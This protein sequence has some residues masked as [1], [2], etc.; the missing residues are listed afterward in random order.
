MT[1]ALSFRD[2]FVRRHAEALE[3]ARCGHRQPMQPPK[4]RVLLIHEQEAR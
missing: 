4:T 2:D 1:R 3:R